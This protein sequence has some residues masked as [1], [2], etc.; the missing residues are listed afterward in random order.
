M[1]EHNGFTDIHC[2]ALYGVDDGAKSKEESIAMLKGLYSE[3]VRNCIFSFHGRG[4]ITKEKRDLA[5]EH[6]EE[7]K[8]FTAEELPDMKLY[9]GN[10]VLRSHGTLEA[11]Q[12]GRL[13]TLAGS[14]YVLLEFMPDDRYDE[15][16]RKTREVI[17]FGYRP[18]LAHIERYENLYK[19]ENKVQELIRSGA[20]MQVNSRSFMGG[21][22]DSKSKT[23]IKLM[24]KGMIHF[25]ADDTHD[26]SHRPPFI[27][28]AYKH[29]Q[30]K[31]DTDI[32]N[33]V[34][35]ENPKKLLNNESIR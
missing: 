25:I 26:M 35:F 22:F 10:E 33:R 12:E 23:V 2:H 5:Y 32:L 13:S 7:L 3:G 14:K 34:F 17:N 29:L 1:T 27:E 20:Y 8:A 6:Y 30:K 4:N 21:F 18:V 24:K 28:S 9:M 15:I 16:F 11:L 31:V 19:D